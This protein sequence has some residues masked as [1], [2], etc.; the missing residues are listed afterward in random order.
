M[1]YLTQLRPLGL[2]SPGSWPGDE[3]RLESPAAIIRLSRMRKLQSGADLVG[4][5]R[6]TQ[7]GRV[8]PRLARV[9]ICFR[10]IDVETVRALSAFSP[11]AVHT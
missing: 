4:A 9:Y 11:L 10:I 5:P 6:G 1:H 3:G 2:R 8:R 7:Q